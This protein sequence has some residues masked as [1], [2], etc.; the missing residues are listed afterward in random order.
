M[1][2]RMLSNGT[3]ATVQDASAH[4]LWMRRNGRA[5]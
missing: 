3:I 5:M 1:A 2:N 4:L